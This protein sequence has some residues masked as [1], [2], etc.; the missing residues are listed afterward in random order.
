MFFFFSCSVSLGG[1]FINIAYFPS[2]EV[3]KDKKSSV[4]IVSTIRN[5]FA[6]PLNQC[7]QLE[8]MKYYDSFFELFSMV[9]W[10]ESFSFCVCPLSR[11]TSCIGFLTTS[12]IIWIMYRFLFCP[13]QLSA[14]RTS[15]ILSV[16]Q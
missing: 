7:Y 3:S 14:N 6:F 8:R 1:F 12:N 2:N 5:C 4:S 9:E 10:I 15:S 13:G 16:V 11:K